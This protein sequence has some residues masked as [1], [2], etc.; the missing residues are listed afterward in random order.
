MGLEDLE[1]WFKRNVKPGLEDFFGGWRLGER[2]HRRPYAYHAFPEG[3]PDP[4][5]P[6]RL[7]FE[8]R[9]YA[10][11]RLVLEPAPQ[12]PDEKGREGAVPVV[13]RGVEFDPGRGTVRYP[14]ISLAGVDYVQRDRIADCRGALRVPDPG[15]AGSWPEEVVLDGREYLRADLALGRGA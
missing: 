14:I 12:P 6:E 1:G 13:T 9:L 8:E 5:S 15:A 7:L 4:A 3:R 2:A 11:R 10:I